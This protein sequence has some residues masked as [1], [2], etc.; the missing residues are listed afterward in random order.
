MIFRSRLS[1]EKNHYQLPSWCWSIQQIK[2]NQYN[3][4]IDVFIFSSC[5]C[6][7]EEYKKR[8]FFLVLV[9]IFARCEDENMERRC[10]SFDFG[11][12][13]IFSHSF[14]QL[15]SS[16]SEDDGF[17]M[18]MVLSWDKEH[19]ENGQNTPNM[20]LKHFWCSK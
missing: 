17:I 18:F 7:K 16:S 6:Y 15:F 13:V 3:S 10:Y 8:T 4:F 14:H 11:L 5:T 9:F 20:N 1:K 2:T 19:W 12:L